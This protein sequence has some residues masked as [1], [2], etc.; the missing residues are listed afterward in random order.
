MYNRF[1]HCRRH[2]AE[3]ISESYE[4]DV[5]ASKRTHCGFYKLRKKGDDLEELVGMSAFSL[6]PYN[7][8][9]IQSSGWSKRPFVKAPET[10]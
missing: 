4:L 3:R 8:S 10:S 1:V 9:Q 7:A 2:G 5:H 6:L